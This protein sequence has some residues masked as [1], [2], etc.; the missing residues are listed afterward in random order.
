MRESPQQLISAAEFLRS[1]WPPVGFPPRGARRVL[2]VFPGELPAKRL[3]V[4]RGLGGGTHNHGQNER[5]RPLTGRTIEAAGLA[6][7]NQGEG[8]VTANHRLLL[9]HQVEHRRR[10][11]DY[12]RMRRHN[13]AESGMLLCFCRKVGLASADS[14]RA[15]PALRPSGVAHLSPGGSLGRRLAD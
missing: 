5:G 3:Q 11:R 9:A 7:E 13:P 1:I 12:F 2:P 8:H 15:G 14:L 6:S 10:F 4:Q